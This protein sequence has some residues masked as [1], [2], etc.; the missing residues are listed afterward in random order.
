M[1]VLTKPLGEPY[2]RKFAGKAGYKKLYSI[3]ANKSS[4]VFP[5]IE[6]LQFIWS[7]MFTIMFSHV[8][9]TNYTNFNCK[10]FN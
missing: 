4:K 2:V 8:E 5:K 7:K 1:I 6:F 3:Y 10:T 9:N